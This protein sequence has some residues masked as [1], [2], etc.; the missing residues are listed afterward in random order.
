MEAISVLGRLAPLTLHG[1]DC[2]AHN[3]I[4]LSPPQMYAQ[5]KFPLIGSQNAYS[6]SNVT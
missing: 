5:F 1:S 2:N 4:P 6:H 3:Y